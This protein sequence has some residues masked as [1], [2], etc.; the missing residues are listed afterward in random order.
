MSR[1]RHL[2]TLGLGAALLAATLAVSGASQA[3]AGKPTPQSA[4]LR[5]LPPMAATGVAPEPAASALSVL[6]ADFSPVVPGRQV[7]LQRQTGTKWVTVQQLS[8]IHI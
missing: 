3:G 8:L 7:L 6:D 5:M 1:S 4:Q 2:G